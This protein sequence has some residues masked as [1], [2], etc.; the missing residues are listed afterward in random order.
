LTP[1]AA[2]VLERRPRHT[3]PARP[4]RTAPSG[5]PSK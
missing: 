1:V 2:P 5:D 3:R 4:A